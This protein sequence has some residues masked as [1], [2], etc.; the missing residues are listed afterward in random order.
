M[1]NIL[2]LGEHIMHIR[3]ILSPPLQ[4][5]FAP[6]VAVNECIDLSIVLYAH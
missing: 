2:H 3:F 1:Q 5:I 4:T 6:E